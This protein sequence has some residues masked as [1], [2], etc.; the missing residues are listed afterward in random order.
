LRYYYPDH[1]HLTP[2]GNL[3]KARIYE[4]FLDNK[5]PVLG[6]GD[7]AL[8]MLRGHPYLDFSGP[9]YGGSGLAVARD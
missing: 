8:L 7:S 2:T 3:V 9:A 4:Q 6:Y 5:G 1:L